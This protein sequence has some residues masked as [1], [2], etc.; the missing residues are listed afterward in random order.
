MWGLPGPS[1]L[2]PAEPC[3]L[4]LSFLVFWAG[5]LRRRAALRELRSQWA[6]TTLTLTR[7]FT[8]GAPTGLGVSTGL[9]AGRMGVGL[10]G[11]YGALLE[12]ALL[13]P[14]SA[15]LVQ[16]G[17]LQ[18]GAFWKDNCIWEKQSYLYDLDAG[19]SPP[20]PPSRRA[21]LGPSAG[22]LSGPLPGHPVGRCSGCQ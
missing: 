8:D 13:T 4:I 14:V 20:S 2:P 9:G 19:P 1:H 7:G 12:G 6:P 18:P 17:A 22:P 16:R 5:R 3:C 15:L 11:L 21:L 10:S